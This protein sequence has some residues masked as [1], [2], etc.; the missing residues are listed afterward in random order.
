MS[1]DAAGSMLRSLMNSIPTPHDQRWTK[2]FM[3][4]PR[5]VSSASAKL[6]SEQ[7]QQKEQ[8]PLLIQSSA[9]FTNSFVPPDYLIDGLLQRRYFYLLTGRTG[10]AKTSLALLFAACVALGLPV[11][12]LETE[13]G[14]VLFFAGENADDTRA[15][16]IALAQQMQFDV[17]TIDVHF[18]P[19]KFSISQLK[20]R[21]YR[22]IEAL[23]GVEF[24]IVDT[25]STYFETDDEND[26]MQMLR[27]AHLLRGLTALPGGPCILANCHP[28]KHAT[29]DNLLPRGG[30][31]FLNECDGNLIARIDDMKVELHWQGKFRGPDFAPIYFMLK[32]GV[33]HERLKDTKGRLIPTV[34]ASHLSD[35]A[36]QEMTKNARFDEDLLLQAVSKAPAAAVTDLAREL[37]WYTGKGEPYKSKV[38]RIIKRL[39]AQ[40]LLKEERGRFE[41]TERGQKILAAQGKDKRQTKQDSDE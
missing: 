36:R 8:T 35:V 37:N 19:G 23:G 22:E 29:D 18:I 1:E 6:D 13:R 27:H 33:T 10:S 16:W 2:R 25:S 39:K 3:E 17:E 7:P 4:I 30:G 11:G 31:S 14:R 40:K 24:L 9:Q 21:I 12:P 34:V 20:Q 32:S 41:L 28:A 15:R 26:A 38:H 5:L